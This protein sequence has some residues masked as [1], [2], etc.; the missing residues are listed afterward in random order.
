MILARADYGEKPSGSGRESPARPA[1]SKGCTWHR[2]IWCCKMLCHD[3][4]RGS[5]VGYYRSRRYEFR[6]YS[7]VFQWS[8]KPVIAHKVMGSGFDHAINQSLLNTAV[9]QQGVNL[10]L[11][12]AEGNEQ[13]HGFTRTAFLKDFME[14]PVTRGTIKDAVFLEQGE[15]IR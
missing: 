7:L 1:V 4:I 11:T 10:R 13:F 2:V 5:L 8:R 6:G 14:K 9:S 3:S 15:G 12:S